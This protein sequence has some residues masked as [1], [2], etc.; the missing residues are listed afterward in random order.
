MIF[1]DGGTGPGKLHISPE[2]YA[3]PLRDPELRGLNPAAKVAKQL[4][5]LL[6]KGD[7]CMESTMIGSSGLEVEEIMKVAQKSAHSIFSVSARAVKNHAKDHGIKITDE[8]GAKD[9]SITVE[10]IQKIHERGGSVPCKAGGPNFTRLFTSVRPSDKRNYEDEAAQVALVVLPPHSLSPKNAMPFGMALIEWAM[11]GGT[12]RESFEK[13]LGGY[14][15]GYPS[16]YRRACNELMKEKLGLKRPSEATKAQRKEAWRLA[17]I[18]WRR[19]FAERVLLTQEQA[20]QAALKMGK[21]P[22]DIKQW[23]E[24]LPEGEPAKGW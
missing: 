2:E 18:E 12:R 8:N 20:E 17:A 4:V 21:T 13:I 7:I 22:L 16:F 1:V 6:Q 11:I 5:R 10:L 15:H 9:H 24:R 3:T 14:E 23:R 19:L